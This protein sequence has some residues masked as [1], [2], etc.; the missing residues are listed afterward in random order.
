[1]KKLLVIALVFVIVCGLIPQTRSAEASQAAPQTVAPDNAD[2]AVKACTFRSAKLFRYN[3]VVDGYMVVRHWQKII[4]CWNRSIIQ[5]WKL[6]YGYNDY[7]ASWA[8]YGYYDP[9]IQGNTARR[10][11]QTSLLFYGYIGSTL[12]YWRSYIWQRITRAGG[13]SYDYW[14]SLY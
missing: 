14:S 11:F 7:S 5:N 6:S 3:L 2:P 9:I 12:W 1:M 8:Y 4:W 10:T 13:Y